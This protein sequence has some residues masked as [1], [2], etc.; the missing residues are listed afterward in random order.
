MS[1]RAF[2]PIKQLARRLLAP[3]RAWA[4]MSPAEAFDLW[5][6]TYDDQVDNPLF[7][8]DDELT[9]HLLANVPLEGK[10]IV[11]VGCGSGRRW[12]RLLSDRPERLIGY[13]ASAGMLGRL[14]S[15][16]PSAEAHRVT[17][18]RL[19]STPDRSCDLLISTLT[20][21]YI[22]DVEGAFEEWERVLKPGGD[23]ILTD[24]HPDA[25]T[26]EARSFRQNNRTI[27]IRHLSRSLPSIT[28][29]A[30]RSG[31][32]AV[33]T[34]YVLVDQSGKAAYEAANPLAPKRAHEGSAVMFGMRLVRSARLADRDA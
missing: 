25:A 6:A 2:Q 34:E 15:K 19:R 17:D 29:A 20:L 4:R 13:D 27:A 14:R 3:L 26:S 9:E 24:L 32:E 22:A 16:F 28:A 30:K 33:R 10:V 21:G 5:S 18:H 23:V 1:S 12:P 31:L 11:D 8:L 7:P